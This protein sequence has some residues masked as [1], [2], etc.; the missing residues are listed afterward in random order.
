MRRLVLVILCAAYAVAFFGRPSF[1]PGRRAGFDPLD[2][3]AR[4]VE[5]AIE[6][7]HFDDALVGLHELESTFP[8]DPTVAYWTA[9]TQRGLGNAVEEAEAWER[10]LQQAKATGA[11]C[12]AL[13]LA[14]ARAGD[15]NRALDAYQRC[16]T[17]TPGD[18]EHWVEL[19]GA[20]RHVGRIAE[21]SGALA[22][23]HELDPSN[24][25]LR[26]LGRTSVDAEGAAR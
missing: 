21:A 11:A 24:P 23:A 12:P 9:E 4:R 2:P 3:R 10:V 26:D 18:P 25:E 15:E 20:Y 8:S 13:P 1:G 7:Q 6:Q 22:K 17:M 14:Y 16:A 5:Q 19:A